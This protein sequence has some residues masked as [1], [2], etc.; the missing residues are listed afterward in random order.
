MAQQEVRRLFTYFI[1]EATPSASA[2][3]GY[4]AAVD[5]AHD[6]PTGSLTEEDH[7]FAKEFGALLAKMGDDFAEFKISMKKQEDK[8]NRKISAAI[9]KDD[10]NKFGEIVDGVLKDCFG[11]NPS[12]VVKTLGAVRAIGESLSVNLLPKFYEVAMRFV[13]TS[14]LIQKVETLHNVTW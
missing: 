14:G 9:S 8:W 5:D 6:T 13:N 10:V 2:G 1:H 4:E 11:Q 3:F 12:D 7:A